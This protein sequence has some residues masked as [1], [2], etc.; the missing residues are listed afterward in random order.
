MQE[1]QIEADTNKGEVFLEVVAVVARG[2][3]RDPETLAGIRTRTKWPWGKVWGLQVDRLRLPVPNDGP[4]EPK[5]TKKAL[6]RS[7]ILMDLRAKPGQMN[8]F[9]ILLVISFGG[10][11]AIIPR[12]LHFRF[13]KITKVFVL[14]NQ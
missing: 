8:L 12:F 1:P 6:A 10:W 2:V 7:L 3:P 4:A 9:P 13:S 5:P 14:L 11:A